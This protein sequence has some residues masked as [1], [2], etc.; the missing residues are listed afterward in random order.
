MKKQEIDFSSIPAPAISEITLK[1]CLKCAFDFFTKQLGFTPHTAYSE[2]KK[3]TPEEADFTGA[4]TIRPH[5]FDKEKLARCPYCNGAKNWFA[6]FHATRIDANPSFE[7]Q[8]KRLWTAL[9]KE[10][11][12]VAL[13]KSE[14]T[15]MEIFSDW[16]DRLKRRIDFADDRWLITVALDYVKRYAP[17]GE[18]YEITDDQVQRVQLS[19]QLDGLWKYENQWLYVTPSIYGD[20]LIVQHL[21]SRSQ[22]AGGRTFEGRLTLQELINRLRRVGYF[23]VREVEPGSAFEILEQTIASIVASGPNAVYYAVD[24]SD[25]LKKLKSVYEKKRGR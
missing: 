8:R 23:Q 17:S 13:W 19:R 2:L 15:Q 21:L 4:A 22:Q 9:R 12:R 11:D 5:F 10:P 7:K 6:G 24:R 3:H 14:R 20:A 25:Y 16:L 1:I 18:G